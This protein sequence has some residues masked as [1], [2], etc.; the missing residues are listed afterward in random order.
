MN[1]LPKRGFVV[2]FELTS[3][4]ISGLDLTP[5]AEVYRND[6][7]KDPAPFKFTFEVPWLYSSSGSVR[8]AECERGLL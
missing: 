5:L 1:L 6:Q 8:R 4:L 3:T 2:H 7:A